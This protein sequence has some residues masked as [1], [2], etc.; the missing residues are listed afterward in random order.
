MRNG[1]SRMQRNCT[2]CWRTASCHVKVEMLITTILV[3]VSVLL[4][5]S[6]W[7][8]RGVV[9]LLAS[10]RPV[11]VCLCRQT[12]HSPL[13]HPTERHFLSRARPDPHRPPIA[14]TIFVDGR[15]DFSCGKGFIASIQIKLSDNGRYNAKS[16]VSFGF[17]AWRNVIM[18]RNCCILTRFMNSTR[19]KR[20][21]RNRT[22]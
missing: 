13:E 6:L 12:R 17:S 7:K 4:C 2:V 21:V 5:Q 11:S 22:I 16:P 1:I 8:S 15:C 20:R 18:S 9:Y 3:D 10:P 19:A 14:H